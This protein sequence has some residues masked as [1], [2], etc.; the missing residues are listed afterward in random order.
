M[1][2]FIIPIL[3]LCGACSTTSQDTKVAI[4]NHINI[5]DS[6]P[7]Y[8]ILEKVII[9]REYNGTI[10]SKSGVTSDYSLILYNQQHSG[11]GVFEL[12]ILSDNKDSLLSYGKQ[13][14]LRGDATDINATVY[15]LV[16]FKNEPEVNLLKREN[17]LVILNKDFE[18]D[19]T[20]E[21][22]LLHLTKESV[23]KEK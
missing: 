9:K 21:R 15:Q 14:T 19:S 6:L 17:D 10:I 1:R 12:N 3:I 18:I 16:G 23:V 22:N 20:I 2:L 5:I 7:I 8:D 11:D 4:N 13:Y